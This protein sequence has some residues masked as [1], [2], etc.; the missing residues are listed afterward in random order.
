[1]QPVATESRL[2]RYRK[3]GY[4]RFSNTL[5]TRCRRCCSVES[6]NGTT[7]RQNGDEF[8]RDCGAVQQSCQQTDKAEQ[9]LIGILCAAVHRHRIE[10]QHK[11]TSMSRDL[12]LGMMRFADTHDNAHFDACFRLTQPDLHSRSLVAGLCCKQHIHQQ[13]S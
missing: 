12:K 8:L 11:P 1:M 5:A 2:L 6:V 3:C 9:G 13:S 7:L 10:I 4:H